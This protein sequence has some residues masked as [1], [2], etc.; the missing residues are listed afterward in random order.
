MQ[1][2]VGPQFAS[3]PSDKLFPARSRA[4]IRYSGSSIKCGLRDLP[5]ADALLHEC[6]LQGT[7]GGNRTPG[8]TM[9]ARITGS[10]GESLAPG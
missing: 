6:F 4:K 9:G 8:V 3:Q 2:A 1:C 10:I 5:M 7:C